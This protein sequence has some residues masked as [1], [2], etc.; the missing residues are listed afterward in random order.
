MVSK[1][2]FSSW[3][4]RS[5]K[6][7]CDDYGHVTGRSYPGSSNSVGID[8]PHWNPDVFDLDRVVEELFAL[9]MFCSRPISC[10]LTVVDPCPLDILSRHVLNKL[11]PLCWSEVPDRLDVLMFGQVLG[12][13][14][15]LT[16]DDVDDPTWQVRCV[17]HLKQ[18]QMILTKPWLE[19]F[20]NNKRLQ[21]LGYNNE[22]LH[23]HPVSCL[24]ESDKENR[25]MQLQKC[26]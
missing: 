21:L 12:Q 6:A 3:F 7:E 23:V 4:S 19:W 24:S 11:W 13:V 16:C 20:I 5:L 25:N 15:A 26:D 22:K 1:T 8:F 9:T 18:I 17:K 2:R 10:F 14:V